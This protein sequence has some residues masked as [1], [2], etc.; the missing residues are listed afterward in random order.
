MEREVCV[1]V[2]EGCVGYRLRETERRG[3]RGAKRMRCSALNETSLLTVKDR[4]ERGKNRGRVRMRKREQES[5][6]KTS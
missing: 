3:R 5:H 6:K 1:C 4:M 2:C